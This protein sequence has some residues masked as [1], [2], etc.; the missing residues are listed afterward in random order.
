MGR[1]DSVRETA[2]GKPLM[3][4]RRI[5]RAADHVTGLAVPGA[6]GR[7]EGSPVYLCGTCARCFIRK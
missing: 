1:G 4:V 5:G 6:A 3:G 2:Y 7:T